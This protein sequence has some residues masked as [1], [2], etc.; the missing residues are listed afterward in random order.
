MCVCFVIG[1]ITQGMAQLRPF[2]AMYFQNRYLANPAMAAS[3]K[4]IDVNV[5]YLR[6]W[7]TVP[8]APQAQYITGTYRYT[9]KVGLGVGVFNETTGLIRQTKFAA[10]YSYHLVLNAEK[11]QKLH[12]GLSAGFKNQRLDMNAIQGDIDDAVV[13]SYNDRPLYFDGDFGVAFTAKRLT[14][15]ASL[16]NAR[17]TFESTEG[18]AGTPTFFASASYKF[19]VGTTKTTGLEPMVS[20]R[21][22]KEL[23]GI[24]DVGL[25]ATFLENTLNFFAIY[26]SSKSA[27]LGAGVRITPMFR[28]T[29]VYL[30]GA[31]ALQSYGKDNFE[32]GLQVLLNQD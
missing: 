23:G 19:A 17:A 4:G 1:A 3:G 15:Q 27:S 30:T 8:G 24:V 25:N 7:M 13:L 6:Q 5:G 18:D 10:T 31:S 28:F 14:V 9:E 2:S 16:P 21:G 11:D 29:G 12:F 32:L 20:Y 22:V 26:H